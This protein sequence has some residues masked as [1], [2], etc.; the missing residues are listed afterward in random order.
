MLNHQRVVETTTWTPYVLPRDAASC[1][2]IN[3]HIRPI[4]QKGCART[5]PRRHWSKTLGEV[6]TGR[7]V[8]PLQPVEHQIYIYICIK[9]GL[10]RIFIT[11]L[12]SV[13]TYGIKGFLKWGYPQS[14]LSS[15][16]SMG[17]NPS[18][19][20]TPNWWRPRGTHPWCETIP[21][22][23]PS[24][25]HPSRYK[26]HWP[27]P[28]RCVKVDVGWR[29]WFSRENLQRLPWCWPWNMNNIWLNMRV[30]C[31]FSLEPMQWSIGS[32][33]QLAWNI[34]ELT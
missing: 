14:S 25:L 18:S 2:S 13:Y 27:W 5:K 17:T 3:E 11:P 28:A 12:N 9:I 4:A 30:S 24:E 21:R 32:L 31:K 10:K 19:W 26:C 1:S 6:R 20:G 15:S 34:P 7:V 23:A 22:P 33:H 16:I 29:D 8:E